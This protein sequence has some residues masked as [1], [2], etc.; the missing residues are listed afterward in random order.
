LPPLVVWF[1]ALIVGFSIVMMA[2]GLAFVLGVMG[3]MQW[4]HGQFYMVSAFI[5]YSLF[6]QMG[7]NYFV[8]LIISTVAIAILGVLVERILIRPVADKGFLASSVV[9][10]GLSFAIQGFITVLYGPNIKAVPTVL[11]GK[12]AVGGSFISWQRLL[13][14]ILAIAAMIGLYFFVNK[15]KMGLSMRAA[16]QDRPIAGLFGVRTGRVFSI[17]MVVGSGLAALAGGLLAPVY[18][19]DPTIGGRP[20]TLALLAIV[21]GGMGSFL[22]AVVGGLIFGFAS[23]ILNFYIGPWYEFVLFAVVIAVILVRPQGLFGMSEGRV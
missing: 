20:L 12:V 6:A 8:T 18:S 4:S 17:V 5:V 11:E 10:L 16:S 2:S 13:V 15:T 7:L 22:G 21:L 14:V 23:M 3:I 9:T 1:D 19:V